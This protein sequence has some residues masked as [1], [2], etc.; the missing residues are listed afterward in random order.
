MIDDMGIFRTTLGVAALGTPERRRELFDVM[1]D[2]G[3]EYNWIPST[4][5][6]E[7]GVTPVRVDRFETADGRRARARA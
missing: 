5:L 4:V 2:T 7:L 3:S 1:V 6:V